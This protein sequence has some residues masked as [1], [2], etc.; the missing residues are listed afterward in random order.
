LI[1][2]GIASGNGPRRDRAEGPQLDCRRALAGLQPC[3]STGRN[4]GRCPGLS[5]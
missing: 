4:P 2:Q 3:R 1:A 5:T